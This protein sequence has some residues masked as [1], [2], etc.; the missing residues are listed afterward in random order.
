MQIAIAL[1]RCA[2]SWARGL[3]A[4]GV[5]GTRPESG[6]A[7]R[8]QGPHGCPHADVFSRH[9]PCCGLHYP[10]EG[11]LCGS[12]YCCQKSHSGRLWPTSMHACSVKADRDWVLEGDA[13]V[14]WSMSSP[15][16]TEQLTVFRL[17][18]FL[19]TGTNYQLVVAPEGKSQVSWTLH[20]HKRLPFGTVLAY[21]HVL[22]TRETGCTCAVCCICSVPRASG[23][24]IPG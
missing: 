2:C 22:E 16:R 1:H 17:K 23:G 24:S 14:M 6:W 4:S 11:R 8:S 13:H 15:L 3:T 9:T 5:A 10:A 20:L 7:A 21:L 18:S 19:R 12:P